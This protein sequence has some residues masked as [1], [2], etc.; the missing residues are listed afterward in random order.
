[1]NFFFNF[2]KQALHISSYENLHRQ[3][4]LVQHGTSCLQ[5]SVHTLINKPEVNSAH[6]ARMR[7]ARVGDWQKMLIA[8][9]QA[10]LCMITGCYNVSKYNNTSQTSQNKITNRSRLRKRSA[11]SAASLPVFY[12]ERTDLCSLVIAVATQRLQRT[13]CKYSNIDSWLNDDHDCNDGLR[14]LSLHR[15]SLL[16]WNSLANLS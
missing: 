1:M 12:W 6:A 13:L 11:L 15:Q 14:L 16:S 7:Y 2:W 10:K 4:C 9:P 8:S 5:R 3:N